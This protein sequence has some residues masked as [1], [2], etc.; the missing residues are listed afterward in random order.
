MLMGRQFWKVSFL[1]PSCSYLIS[2]NSV[3]IIIFLGTQKCNSVSTP[4]E[5]TTSRESVS[6]LPDAFKATCLWT[7]QN[8]ALKK[9]EK[10]KHGL[11]TST[12]LLLLDVWV[13]LLEEVRIYVIFSP[14]LSSIF[15]TGTGFSIAEP[16]KTPLKPVLSCQSVRFYLLSSEERLS[17]VVC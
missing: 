12:V 9:R 3:R 8:K 13:H 11:W 6:W 15:W 14:L 5:S 4:G 10:K 1:S 17:Q 7:R 16:Q 2:V